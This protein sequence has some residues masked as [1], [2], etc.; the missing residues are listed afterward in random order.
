MSQGD[1]PLFDQHPLSGDILLSTGPAPVPYHVYDGHGLLVLGTCETAALD[2]SF[3]GQDVHPV[4]TRAGKGV[5]VVFICD[6]PRASHGAHSEFHITALC[7][8]TK[9]ARLSDDPAAAL[10]SLATRPEWGVLSLHLWNDAAPVVAYNTEYLGLSAKLMTGKI[11]KDADRVHFAFAD[12][13]GAPLASGAVAFNARSDA[14]LMMRIMR[15]LGLRGLWSAARNKTSQAAVIN[16]KSEVI[17]HNGRAT[18]LTCPDKMVVTAF[19]PARDQFTLSG[20]L[21]ALQFAP[22]IVEHLWPFRFVYLHPD[23]G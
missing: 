11:I 16:R 7:A 1:H 10:A 20:P 19:D 22:L 5:L 17:A 23:K 21:S 18:T 3:D 12:A 9:G 8:P 15:H 2:R 13:D 4:L 14:G 6:F